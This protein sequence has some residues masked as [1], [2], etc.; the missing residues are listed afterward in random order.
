MNR[1]K[2]I[3]LSRLSTSQLQYFTKKILDILSH[4]TYSEEY[5]RR[6]YEALV[7]ASKKLEELQQ[8]TTSNKKSQELTLLDDEQDSILIGIR[9]HCKGRIALRRFCQKSAEACETILIQMNEYGRDLI[10]GN[11]EKQCVAI[12][13]FLSRMESG[14]LAQTVV[15][16]GVT[17]YFDTLKEVHKNFH[18]LYLEQL[19]FVEKPTPSSVEEK[20]KIRYRL[21]SV[22][23]HI[24]NHLYDET[25]LYD[26]LEIF[27]N[28]L[29]T[30][31]MQLI[32][33]QK[34]PLNT[35]PN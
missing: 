33:T 35:T 29:I 25:G 32:K 28:K 15:D 34:S 12:P 13:S 22:L 9:E 16:A 20:K 24:D 6:Q 19:D 8:Q 7:E 18:D 31:V 26:G 2:S 30:E 23:L 14:T 11:Y 4:F 1:L 5:I 17:P 21:D 3:T 27:I 10:Y